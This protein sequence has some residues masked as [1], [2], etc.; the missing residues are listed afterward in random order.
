MVDALPRRRRSPRW[1][2]RPSWSRWR[3][4]VAARL[5]AALRAC[6]TSPARSS[7]CG[8]SCARSTAS[9][10]RA[11]RGSSR[12]ARSPARRPRSTRRSRRCARACARWPCCCGR[13]C[14]RRRRCMLAAVG[15]AGDDV[16]FDRA[17]LG[18]RQ[19]PDGRRVGRALF[20]RID[21]PPGVIDTH[22]H[23]QGLEG[24]AEAAIEEAAAAGVER[25]VCVGDSPELARGG[26]RPGARAIRASSPPSGLHPHRAEAL[27]R[28]TCAPSLDAPARRPGGRGR[29]GVR[30]RL[31]P[32]PR[33]ARGPGDGVRRP[34]RA[35]R[36]ARQAARDPHARG[37][38]RHAR[39]AARDARAAVDPA[40]LLA[41]RAPRR[42][43]RARLVRVVRGQ[44]RPTRRRAPLAEAARRVPA[45]LLLLETDCPYL[46]PVPL[47]RQAQP[48]ALRARD[49]AG[50]RG[51]CAASPPASWPSRSRRTRRA[52]SPCRERAAPGHARP[53]GR[54]RA[55]AGPAS[56]ASTSWSTT[57]C[58]A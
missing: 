29:G 41:A 38:G 26:D 50:G 48:P 19:R 25:I 27:E 20:P 54:A 30:P 28:R 57:T 12:R 5:R 34:G 53:P 2:R 39:R 4:E 1:R 33:L 9:S 18:T 32:R 17:V 58:S 37:G 45:E 51:R 7:A 52:S 8:S 22:A 23:L 42:G 35:R 14:R 13:S 56:S 43:R 21:A 15:E 16:G 6:S 11:R 44:R 24:G 36:A 46:S 3:A 49:A 10:S 55:A 40:L 47:P 31:L